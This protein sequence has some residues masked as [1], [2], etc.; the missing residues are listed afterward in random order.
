MKIELNVPDYSEYGLRA[1]WE[2]E[3][4]V[5]SAIANNGLIISANRAGLISLAIHLLTLAQDDVPA[6][7]DIHYDDLWALE[8]GSHPWSVR[9]I[10]DR[11]DA[12]PSLP[13]QRSRIKARHI[14]DYLSQRA[15]NYVEGAAEER[16]AELCREIF[17]REEM[18][19]VVFVMDYV[20]FTFNGPMLS[21]F[22]H[23][24]VE[25]KGNILQWEDSDYRD[26]LCGLI[27]HSITETTIRKDDSTRI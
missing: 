17:S 13:S 22:T 24:T 15:A 11:A 19:S 20:Q 10:D 6:G 12:F 27:T 7:H 9:K 8:K 4:I 3:S 23:P 26:A 25:I 2:D 21:A 1:A 5:G 16:C 14:R 18:N